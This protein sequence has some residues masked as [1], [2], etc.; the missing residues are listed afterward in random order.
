VAV[1]DDPVA[2]SAVRSPAISR[3][4]M[5]A[6]MTSVIAAGAGWYFWSRNSSAPPAHPRAVAVLPFQPLVEHLGNES[7]ELGM[8]D[9]LINRLSGL[10]G[11][12]VAPLS[13]VRGYGDRGQ[14][15]LAAGRELRVSAVLESNVQIQPERVRLTARLLDVESGAALWSG[16][17]DEQLSDLFLVQDALA[18]QIVEALEIPLTRM[19]IDRLSRR[20][21][22]DLEAWQL[23]LKGRFNWGTRAED[24]L[25]QAIVFYEAALAADPEFALA[26]AGLADAWA[27]LAIFSLDP[28]VQA[29]DRAR[30]A[31]QRAVALDP[32]LAE[33]QASLGHVMVHGDRDWKGGEALFRKSLALNSTY[34]QAAFWLGNNLCM[35]GDL[36]GALT[37]ARLA[38]AMEPVSVPFAANVG[39]IQYYVR[40]F[41]GA[42]RTLADL[43]AT[44]P[45]YPL[46]RRYLA[47]VLM[48]QGN[49][50]EAFELLRGHEKEHAPGWMSDVGRLFALDGQVEAARREILRIES[51]GEQGFGVGYDLALIH[52]P[53][54]EVDEAL[55]AL[56]R[57]VADGSPLIGFLNVEPQFDVIRDDARFRAI[58]RALTLG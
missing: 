35:Q 56:Q 30:R 33:A 36:A 24:G 16:Q 17:F 34:A 37:H 39:L 57:G 52:A 58:S 43:F 40:D 54:G 5:L 53:L 25:R 51:L 4:A 32:E 10:P 20:P 28:P 22:S 31:A 14:D 21:T 38:Q 3:R 11:V 15:P 8:A 13:S 29:L 19:S 26:A 2:G 41:D 18:R 46:V 45:N 44:L 1:V 27:V 42:R 49:L 48:A 12:V 6:G 23:Y 9:A 7:L 55:H 50:P 47:R